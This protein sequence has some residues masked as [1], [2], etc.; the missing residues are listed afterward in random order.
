MTALI[1]AQHFN[2][3]GHIVK[4]QLEQYEKGKV[5]AHIIKS[6][7]FSSDDE[8]EIRELFIKKANV[9]IQLDYVNSIALTPRGKS[10][11][12]IQHIGQ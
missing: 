3:L 9:D 8:E 1:F 7:D 11:M 5:I 2:A 4:W 6:D 12:L 10:K